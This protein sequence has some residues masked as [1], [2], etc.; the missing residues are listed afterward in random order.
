[1]YHST[2]QRRFQQEV[3]AELAERRE[4]AGTECRGDSERKGG[5]LVFVVLGIVTKDGR[6]GTRIPT[7]IQEQLKQRRRPKCYSLEP[8]GPGVQGV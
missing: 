8:E 3:K 7:D 6:S 2:H 1:M 4:S 5:S